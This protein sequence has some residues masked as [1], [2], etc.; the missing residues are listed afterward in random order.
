MLA[1]NKKGIVNV[2]P[3]SFPSPYYPLFLY[4]FLKTH[5]LISENH[6]SL[7]IFEKKPEG[8]YFKQKI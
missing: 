8:R 5:Y 4:R 1:K 3:P 2:H 6:R 7:T